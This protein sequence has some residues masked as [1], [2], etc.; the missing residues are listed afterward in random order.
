MKANYRLEVTFSNLDGF[1]FAEKRGFIIEDIAAAETLKKKFNE[2][3]ASTGK[4]VSYKL[5]NLQE[6][7]ERLKEMFVKG[8]FTL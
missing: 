7:R 8:G 3:S 5:V 6:E 2:L 4:P 1:F